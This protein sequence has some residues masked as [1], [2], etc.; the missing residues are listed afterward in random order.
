MDMLKVS[1]LFMNATKEI[2]FGILMRLYFYGG[3]V[4]DTV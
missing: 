2:G 3:E 1:V 4:N